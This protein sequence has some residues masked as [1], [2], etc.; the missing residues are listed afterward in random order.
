[1]VALS[2]LTD[3]MQGAYMDLDFCSL[4]QSIRYKILTALV[5]PRPIAW[6][7]S[8]NENGSVNLAPYSFFNVLGNAPPVVG[9]GM[10]VRS[11]GSA[12]DTRQNIERE[13]QFV[14][15]LVD[16]ALAETMHASAAP[17]AKGVSEADALGVALEPSQTVATPRVVLSK[18]HLECEYAQTVEIGDNRIILG[19]VLHLHTADGLLDPETFHVQPGAFVGVGRLQ[20]PGWYCDSSTQFDLGSMPLAPET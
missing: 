11:D 8:L 17:F 16:R 20:G 2:L 3:F 7:T 4:K 1:L 13:G 14:V 5:V 18:V 10:G 6:V 12:K 9:L 15:N 19:T